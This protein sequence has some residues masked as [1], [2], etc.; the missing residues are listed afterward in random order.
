MILALLHTHLAPLLMKL[1][2]CWNGHSKK[3]GHFDDFKKSLAFLW[4]QKWLKGLRGRERESEMV[5]ECKNEKNPHGLEL[6]F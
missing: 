1:K 6:L 3:E 5:V 2:G 4:Y